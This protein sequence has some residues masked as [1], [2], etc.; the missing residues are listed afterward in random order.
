V[1]EVDQVTTSAV[2][3]QCSVEDSHEAEEVV[4]DTHFGCFSL[5]LQGFHP[6]ILADECGDGITHTTWQLKDL[7]MLQ[8][9]VQAVE[10]SREQFAGDSTVTL[11]LFEKQS[12]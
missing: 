2:T 1:I 10:R 3:L 5:L 4:K 9:Q 12:P 11:I 7:W 6:L 8:I